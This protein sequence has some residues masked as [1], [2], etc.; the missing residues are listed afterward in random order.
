M[1]EKYLSQHAKTLIPYVPGE[2]PQGGDLIKLNTN[3]NPYPPSPKVEK[4]ILKAIPNLRLYPPTDGGPLRSAIARREKLPED[5]VFVGNGSDEVLALCFP[6]FFG[7]DRPLRFPEITYSFYPSYARLFE[8]PYTQTRVGTDLSIDIADLTAAGSVMLANP[9]APTSLAL[10]IDTLTD[11]AKKLHARGDMLIVDEAYVE[12][13]A[14]S[15]RQIIEEYDNVLV[16][17][18]LSKSHALAGMRCAYALGQPDLIA[19]LNRAKSSFNSYPLD[20]LAIAAG[21]QALED[22]E[23]FAARRDEIVQTREIFIKDLRALGC[24]VPASKTNFV[25]PKLPR[26]YAAEVFAALREKGIIVRYFNAARID[27]RLRITIGTPMQ[28]QKVTL[29]LREILK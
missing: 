3:E 1:H 7:V 11:M 18:T 28:M 21:A 14:I 6:T 5:W 26:P 4:A 13:G 23:Y 12:F 22:E 20:H 8:I 24:D 29:A 27:E 2:Q 15:C 25:F 19:G 17:R 16:V 9:N 10:G